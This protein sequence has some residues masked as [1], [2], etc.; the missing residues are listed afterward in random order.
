[1][2]DI[3]KPIAFSPH[4]LEKMADRGV[5]KSEVESAIRTGNPEPARKGRFMFRK[6]FAY[7]SLWRGKYYSIKQIVPVVA[8]EPEHLVVVTVYAY[9]F[10]I[11][12]G[13]N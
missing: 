4:A 2:I 6:I 11:A 3:S 9:Y 7:N 12:T 8:E 13:K 10:S 5:S 1:M